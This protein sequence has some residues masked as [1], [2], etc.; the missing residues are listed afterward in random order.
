[1]PPRGAAAALLGYLDP[2]RRLDAIGRHGGIIRRLDDTEEN[3]GR[4][5]KVAVT[6]FR[7]PANAAK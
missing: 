5:H 3:F 6:A 7:S 2:L 4:L 1:M